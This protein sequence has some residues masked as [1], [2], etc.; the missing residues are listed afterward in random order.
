[1]STRRE[2]RP[3]AEHAGDGQSRDGDRPHNREAREERNA[4]GQ[5]DAT[6]SDGGDSE[7]D[8]LSAREPPGSDRDDTNAH[9]LT[10]RR[11]PSRRHPRS[12]LGDVRPYF[13]GR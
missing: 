1:M 11:G 5:E 13:R 9:N 8:G 10:M 12:S 2:R 4:E 7:R 6:S 3:A